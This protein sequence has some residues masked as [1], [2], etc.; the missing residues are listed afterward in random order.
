MKACP[1]GAVWWNEER[2]IPQKCTL[3]AHLLDEGWKKTRC[4]QACPTGALRT[5]WVEDEEMK[6]IAAAQK[7][8]V[9]HPEYRTGPRVYYKNLYRYRHCFIGGS[10]AYE[11]EG[12]VDCAEGAK[13]SLIKDSQVLQ[14]AVTDNYGDFTFDRLEEG[15]GAYTLEIRFGDAEKKTLDIDLK[16]SVNAGIIQ[17]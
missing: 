16:T 3:C 7:L 2:N 5:I 10:V 9:L 17:F 6:V 14:E 15:S 8:E 11:K 13:V 4:A 1:Y 12:V